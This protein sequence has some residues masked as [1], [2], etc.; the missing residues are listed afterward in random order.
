MWSCVKEAFKANLP[1]N[2]DFWLLGILIGCVVAG[3]VGL[4]GGPV[5]A[6]A[7]VAGCLIAVGVTAV[8]SV[9]VALGQA[10]WDCL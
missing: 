10:V 1:Y 3:I 7:L 6:G 5:V 9:I 4:L 8:G 2:L